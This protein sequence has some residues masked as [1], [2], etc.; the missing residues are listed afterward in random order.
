VNCYTAHHS[1]TIITIITTLPSNPI[2]Y[3]PQRVAF[4]VRPFNNS[5]KIL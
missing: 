4:E 3:L 5:L 2:A 1:I